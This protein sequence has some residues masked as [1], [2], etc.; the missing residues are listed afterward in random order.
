VSVNNLAVMAYT[1]AQARQQLLD[2]VAE[3][4]DEIA[5]ALVS[6]GEAYERLDEHTADKLERELFLPI[7]R[8]YG[9][10]QQTHAGFAGRHDLPSGVFEPA[11]PGAPSQGVKDLLDSAVEAV[12]RADS[13]LAT[14]Q[15]SML[16]VEVG[17]A[18]L[19][20][21]LQ[22]VRRLLG[23]LRGRARELVRTLGR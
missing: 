17:D 20:A 13:A 21:G 11:S 19:R 12:G 6:L 16:P 1:A 9:R 14:L 22:D 4:T 15:D 2:T 7:Q 18:D 10:A 8:A 3:A 5:I 23:D